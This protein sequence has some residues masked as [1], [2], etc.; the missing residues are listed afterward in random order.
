MEGKTASQPVLFLQML[1][2]S[3]TES[4]KLITAAPT[5]KN[6]ES[7]A[8]LMSLWLLGVW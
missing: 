3:E 4:C 6:G 8:L 2:F 7:Y 1:S 5:L